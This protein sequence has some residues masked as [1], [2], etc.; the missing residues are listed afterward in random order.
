MKTEKKFNICVS[1][2]NETVRHLDHLKQLAHPYSL[3]TSEII[4][5]AVA[6]EASRLQGEA[7]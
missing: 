3:S 5:L 1:V 2:D 7:R 4:R 6:N